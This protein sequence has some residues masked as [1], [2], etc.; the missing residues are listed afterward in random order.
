MKKRVRTIAFGVC[1]GVSLL[2]VVS[3]SKD[4]GPPYSIPKPTGPAEPAKAATIKVNLGVVGD[5]SASFTV[6]A[7]NATAVYYYVVEKGLTSTGTA[8]SESEIIAKGVKLTSWDKEVVVTGLKSE[9]DY[10]I[11]ALAKNSDGKNTLVEQTTNFKTTQKVDITL[12]L[13]N[14]SSTSTQILFTVL[15]VGAKQVNYKIE[16]KGVVLTADE[17]LETGSRIQN[18]K[19]ATSLKPKGFTAD[20][21][22]VLYVAGVSNTNVKI[23]RSV[24]VRTKSASDEENKDVLQFSTLNFR[25]ELVEESGKK[26]AYYDL[27]FKSADW[28]AT[29]T[30]GAL[31]SIENEIKEGKY[32]LSS[33]RDSGKPSP[34]RIGDNFSIKNAKTGVAEKDIDY[35]DIII[36]KTGTTFVVSIDLVRMDVTK[37]F[38][39]EFKGTPIF[40]K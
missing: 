12:E 10:S 4:D 28:E 7:A 39:A 27:E 5:E 33:K 21:D 3:C 25:T 18:L 29:F 38:K 37:R 6:E 2:A 13:T 22:Y 1:V 34:E 16:K 24:E 15:P 26:I 40:K 30:L 32:V 35:G 14:V 9:T 17:V 8:I 11:M 36:T 31:S 20:T 23:L 19:S